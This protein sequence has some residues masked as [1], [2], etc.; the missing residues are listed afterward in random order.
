MPASRNKLSVKITSM[1]V[2]FF[3]VALT[4]ISLTLLVSRQLEGGAAAINDAGS[5]RMR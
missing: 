2:L 4:A 3:L 1:L 5:Q